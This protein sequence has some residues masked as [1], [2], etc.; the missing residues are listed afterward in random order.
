MRKRKEER[1]K[2]RKKQRNEERKKE[3]NKQ[4]KKERKGIRISTTLLL[5][6]FKWHHGNE[7]ENKTKDKQLCE[8]LPWTNRWMSITELL[9]VLHHSDCTKDVRICRSMD[10]ITWQL[11]QAELPRQ[12][13]A[14][15]GRAANDRSTRSEAHWLHWAAITG[16]HRQTRKRR[17]NEREMKANGHSLTA[18]SVQ[19]SN[20]VFYA[21]SAIELGAKYGTMKDKWRQTDRY[22]LFPSSSSQKCWCLAG[23]HWE[24]PRCA[25][26]G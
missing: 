25:N 6:I 5:V 15:N 11:R 14:V 12:L 9:T 10:W 8:N 16:C 20:L 1:K 2:E 7:R 3:R 4:T 19:V 17:H 18:N 26:D 22:S 24:Y 23:R 21:Q 13:V